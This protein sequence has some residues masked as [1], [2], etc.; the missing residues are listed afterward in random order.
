VP[1]IHPRISVENARGVLALMARLLAERYDQCLGRAEFLRRWGA[2][3]QRLSATPEYEAWRE[4]VRA[5]ARGMCERCGKVG[6]QAHHRK[7]LSRHLELAL[8]QTNGEFVCDECHRDQ[9]PH[10]R[11]F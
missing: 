1:L 10:M 7:Q 8:D 11:G 4:G 5:R 2:L 9:H 3:R 6:K